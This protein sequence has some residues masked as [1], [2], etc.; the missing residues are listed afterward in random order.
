M[1][2]S[3]ARSLETDSAGLRDL[4]PGRL[5][6]RLLRNVSTAA[7][8]AV[9][10]PVA[11]TIL[12]VADAAATAAELAALEHPGD[13]LAVADAA[14]F[15][16]H[17]ALARTPEQLDVLAAAGV[18]DA[19]G[20]G[21]VLL[22]DALVE[23]L[24]GP[25]AEPLIAL[26][27]R[28]RPQHAAEPSTGRLEYEV[29]YAV[30]GWGPEA[31]D[32]LR[33][34]L[35]VLGHSVVV[36]GDRAV[37]Q[38]HVHLAEA[39][40]AIEAALG[41]GTLSQLRI[42]ALPVVGTAERA[43]LAVVAGPG[44][45]AAVT[46]SG[47]IAVRP[48]RRELTVEELVSAAQPTRGDLVVLP[49]DMASLEIAQ[50]QAGQW[51]RQG[52]RVAVIPTVAQVQGLAAVAVHEPTADFDTV[53]V[54]MSS[55]AAH[56]RHGAVTVAESPAMTMAGRCVAGDVLGLVEG[57]F[58]EIGDSALEIGY[59]VALRLLATGAELVTVVAWRRRR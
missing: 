39:G 35:S 9:A 28:D 2:A 52:R 44:I 8:R 41:H 19:G 43:V 34:E 16:A 23:V 36:V 5:V 1:F 55:A 46:E 56:T 3:V 27:G 12:T 22:L 37:A 51:R 42:T 17:Q 31:L 10:R 11:G 20:Q 26:V 24:G 45:A 40:A 21:Y 6:A 48:A 53:V 54:A 13:A 33:R 7:T 47:G 15:G 50:H 57:D 29:M 32:R 49:N 30:R 38:V 4:E 25:E 14:A 18:V 59:A 58:V